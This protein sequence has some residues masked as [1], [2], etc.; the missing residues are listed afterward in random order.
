M[1]E[2]QVSMTKLRHNLGD[3]VNRASYG[4][5]RVIVMSRGEPKA[6][7]IGIDELL[8]LEKSRSQSTAS[9]VYTSLQATDEIRARIKE[10][11]ETYAVEPDDVVDVLHALRGLRDDELGNLR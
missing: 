8:R 5:E 3:L 1:R 11:Q 10:W 2:I 4:G 7:I 9:A 6:A